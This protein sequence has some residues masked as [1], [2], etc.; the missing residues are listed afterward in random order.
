MNNDPL[1]SDKLI[2]IDKDSI[3][4]RNYY[5]PF[6]DKRVRMRD[7]DVISVDKS[8]PFSGKYRYVGTGNFR[9]WF[10]PDNRTKRDKVFIIEIQ[11]KWWRVGFTV[12]D[13]TSVLLLLKQ[14]CRLI[15]NTVDAR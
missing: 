10:P 15:D 7:I 9:V 13:T 2:E 6:G 4:I 12:E 3:L 1:Y 5:F 11:E 14:A 8:K